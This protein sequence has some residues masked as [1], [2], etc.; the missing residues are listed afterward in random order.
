MC[1][2]FREKAKSQVMFEGT[3]G[4]TWIFHSFPDL[5]AVLSLAPSF[6]L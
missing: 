2:F 5:I 6:L 4:A 3:R 1:Q